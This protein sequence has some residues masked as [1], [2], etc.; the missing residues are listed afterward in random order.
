M[1]RCCLQNV[2]KEKKEELDGQGDK[3]G[4]KEIINMAM[5]SC[6]VMTTVFT[7]KSIAREVEFS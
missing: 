2:M 1:K 3:S 4:R 7:K 5:S 6:I